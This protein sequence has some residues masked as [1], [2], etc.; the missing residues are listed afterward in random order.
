[1]KSVNRLHW[2]ELPASPNADIDV[3][4]YMND[5]D[6]EPHDHDFLELAV[7]LEGRGVHE[8]LNGSRPLGPGDAFTIRPGSWHAFAECKQL[9]VAICCV[10]TRLLER[11]LL[12][13]IEE[14][15][16]R[17][18]LWPAL[19][20]SGIVSVKLSAAELR[21]CDETLRLLA[22]PP[23]SEPRLYQMAHL[24]L[25]LRSLADALDPAQLADA[26][27]LASAPAAV[28]EALHLLATDLAHEWSLSEL[29]AE[30]S[31]SPSYLS[32][33][34]HE[35]VGRPP[36]SHLSALRAEAAA[37]RLL[38]SQE[39]VSAIGS[40][41]GWGDPNYFA[42]RFRTHFG[43]SPSAFRQRSLRHGQPE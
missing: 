7:I 27:R 11:E 34:F 14:P 36:M 21:A 25:C 24:L 38:R 16:L 13:L 6:H 2:T 1:M 30:V 5:G 23:A 15:R 18:L 37:T 35:A 19:G 26:A 8:V 42:R 43:I 3:Y 29:A 20:G 9:L 41:V 12:W 17:F 31:L 10:Q 39:P 32:R 4:W 40:S 33:R 22:A 28:V